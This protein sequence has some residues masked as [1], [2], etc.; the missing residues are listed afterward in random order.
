MQIRVCTWES[1]FLSFAS[2]TFSIKTSC[3]VSQSCAKLWN[4]QTRR[5]P[6]SGSLY[7]RIIRHISISTTYI[8]ESNFANTLR[9]LQKHG[10]Y[11]LN[12]QGASWIWMHFLHFEREGN[13]LRSCYPSSIYVKIKINRGYNFL[14][15]KIIVVIPTIFFSFRNF[16]FYFS[17]LGSITKNWLKLECLSIPYKLKLNPM[18]LIKLL[19]DPKASLFINKAN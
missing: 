14:T 19:F 7:P 4:I 10:M 3:C 12:F 13:P 18:E 15:K 16:I 9:I 2:H 17:V 8:V 6:P 11:V 5:K 1:Y